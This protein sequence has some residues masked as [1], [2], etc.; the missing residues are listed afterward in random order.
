MAKSKCILL[1]SGGLDSL[2]A[3]KLLMEQGIEV[4]GLHCILPFYPADMNPEELETSAIAREIGLKLVFYRCGKEY[5][6]MVKNPAHGYGKNINPCIDCKL[7]FMKKAADLMTEMNAD[8]VAT[9]EVVGQRPMSQLKHMLKHLEKIS[10]IRGRLLRPLSAKILEPTIPE[11]EGK[12]D[13]SRLLDISGRGRKRQMEL[14]ERYGIKNYSHP[15][16]GCLFTDK[17]FSSRVIDLFKYCKDCN[18]NDFCLLKIGRHF[19]VNE[20]LKIIVSRNESETVELEKLSGEADCFFRPEF[21]GPSVFA[22]GPV[23]EKEIV[24]INSIISRY[25]KVTENQN[26]II[27]RFKNGDS[28][29]FTAPEPAEDSILEAMRI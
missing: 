14:A 8:F 4:T 20:N 1:Y 18:S 12:V 17:Y 16:G 21:K 6:D 19:R 29:E 2:I 13:R 10:G 23:T 3:A 11:L 25:G 24:L 15:A 22:K 9:G 28:G 7:F 27:I 5:I 26:R